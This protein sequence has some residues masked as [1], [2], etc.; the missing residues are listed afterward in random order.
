MQLLVRGSSRSAG[1]SDQ[2]LHDRLWHARTALCCRDPAT[3]G[4]LDDIITR[5]GSEANIPRAREE[6]WT[7]LSN[8]VEQGAHG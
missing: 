1:T 7:T 4:P 2:Q 8:K 6:G 5:T 3:S